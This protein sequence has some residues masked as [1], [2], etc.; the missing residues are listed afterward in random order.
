M[1]SDLRPKKQFQNSRRQ[2]KM[3]FS[4]DRGLTESRMVE[5]EFDLFK[6]LISREL[7]IEI[8]GD[9]R[10]TFHTKLSHR[11]AILGLNTYRDYYDLIV[12]EPSREELNSLISHITNNETYFQREMARVHVF[13]NL[14]GEIKKHKQK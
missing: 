3:D 11:L 10:L 6:G 9:N 5:E 1:R 13:T 8:K 4:K 7:G 14:L 2:C 12:S